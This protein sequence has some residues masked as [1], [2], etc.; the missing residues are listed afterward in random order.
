M[1]CCV[2][3]AL[4]SPGQAAT[5]FRIFPKEVVLPRKVR[6]SPS[7][8]VSCLALFFALGGSAL[9][10]DGHQA[11]AVRCPAGQPRAIATVTGLP[12]LGGGVPGVFQGLPNHWTGAGRYFGYRWSCSG[13]PI[14]V[15]ALIPD[16]K[17]DT[18]GFD[19][20]FPGNPGHVATVSSNAIGTLATSV[21]PSKD[22]NGFEVRT[23]AY[24]ETGRVGIPEVAMVTLVVF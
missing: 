1:T 20:R 12:D 4:T 11:K 24:A 18:Y 3:D 16:P 22:F 19:I 17:T 23:D 21:S 5:G 15:K 8:V 6:V 13:Q 10:L 7:M 2:P 9:A 14:Q